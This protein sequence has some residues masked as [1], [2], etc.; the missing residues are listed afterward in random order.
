MRTAAARTIITTLCLALLF[1]AD[2]AAAAGA[3]AGAGSGIAARHPLADLPLTIVP[4]V[5][6]TQSPWFG[7]FLSGDGGWAAIDR[8]VAK[9]LAKHGIPIVGW[10]SL[11]YFW[12]ARTPD[13]ASRDL[14][15][16]V[17]HFARTWQKAHVLLIGYS[18]G[19]DSLPFMVNRLPARIHDMVGFTALLGI[20]DNA[21][22]E[23]HIQSWLGSPGKG[24]ATAPELANWTGAP[25]LCLYGERD[26]DAACE[27]LTGKEGVAVKMPGGHHFAKDYPSIAAQILGRLPEVERGGERPVGG[28]PRAGPGG[29]R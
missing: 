13:G 25:Y 29:G 17:Q 7:V 24:I 8:S 4:A 19:A 14:D 15:R 2:A 20:S 9:A 5:P 23:F 22:F 1:A 3:G 12:V 6:G 18:Q 27:Q 10:D 28:A 11:K 16:V 21:L 26:K